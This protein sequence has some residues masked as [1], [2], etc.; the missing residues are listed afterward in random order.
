MTLAPTALMV[1]VV[2]FGSN[3]VPMVGINVNDGMFFILIYALSIFMV[4]FVFHLFQPSPFML[5]AMAGGM[6]WGTGNLLIIHVIQCIGITMAMLIWG[7]V[8]MISGWAAA[9]FGFMGI[10]KEVQRRA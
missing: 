6:I 1:S 2:A 9:M 3:Y 5:V 10:K 7:S 8:A 4:T